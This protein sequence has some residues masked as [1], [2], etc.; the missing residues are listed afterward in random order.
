MRPRQYVSHLWDDENWIFLIPNFGLTPIQIITDDEWFKLA[1]RS[2]TL[3][4]KLD[5]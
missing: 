4:Q 2:P 5:S 1:I 3:T